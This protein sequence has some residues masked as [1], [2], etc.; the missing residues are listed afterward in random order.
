MNL[1]PALSGRGSYFLGSGRMV[2]LYSWEPCRKDAHPSATLWLRS[3][4]HFIFNIPWPHAAIV[5]HVSGPGNSKPAT[6]LVALAV[7]FSHMYTGAKP[8]LGCECAGAV[9]GPLSGVVFLS[10][11][12]PNQSP[13][14]RWLWR[15]TTM[16]FSQ[17]GCASG[18]KYFSNG[19][20]LFSSTQ[21]FLFSFPLGRVSSSLE[22]KIRSK[23]RQIYVLSLQ[24]VAAKPLSHPNYWAA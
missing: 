20:S 15:A 14:I 9:G 10:E 5:I 1:T 22:Q 3:H 13:L 21:F 6:L 12:G 7:I 2:Q 23:A 24:F 11:S 17:G 16:F 8:R 18:M 19:W 4:F